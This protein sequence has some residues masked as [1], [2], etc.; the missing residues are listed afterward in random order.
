MNPSKVKAWCE[1]AS[2]MTDEHIQSP[3]I[4]SPIFVIVLLNDTEWWRLGHLRNHL[5]FMHSRSTF[6]KILLIIGICSILAKT[7]YEA[8]IERTRKKNI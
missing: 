4:I 3:M 1:S 5:L 8:Q 7:N 6:Y 2:K